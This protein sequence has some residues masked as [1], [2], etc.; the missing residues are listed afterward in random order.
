MNVVQQH[1]LL[2]SENQLFDR[3]AVDNPSR[4][5]NQLLIQSDH[6][7]ARFSLSG[8]EVRAPLAA[9]QAITS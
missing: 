9:G 6:G 8:S 7:I 4:L 3:G 2:I 5:K 1:C